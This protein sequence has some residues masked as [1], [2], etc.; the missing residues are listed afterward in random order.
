MLAIDFFFFFFLPFFSRQPAARTSTDCQARHQRTLQGTV[1]L[2]DISL[3]CVLS[4][5]PSTNNA[6]IL[7]GTA[8][9]GKLGN[10]EPGPAPAAVHMYI[11]TSTSSCYLSYVETSQK[12]LTRENRGHGNG[13]VAAPQVRSAFISMANSNTYRKTNQAGSWAGIALASM[14]IC[15][16]ENRLR[17]ME[18]PN[19]LE[20]HPGAWIL[21]TCAWHSIMPRFSLET[22][23]V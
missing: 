2:S 9:T 22:K 18:Y 19:S 6:F 17:E 3:R 20:H 1:F 12:H 23:I 5:L 21:P 15:M 13:I 8:W 10:T 14:C 16:Y 7:V 11:H 4:T